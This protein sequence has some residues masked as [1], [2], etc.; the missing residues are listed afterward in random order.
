MV[1][2]KGLIGIGAFLAAVS[3]AY[4]ALK[5]DVQN[6]EKKIE[7]EI[8]VVQQQ[9]KT[10]TP[11]FLPKKKAQFLELKKK[12]AGAEAV[13]IL[14][15]QAVA[16]LEDLQNEDK[17]EG[18]IQSPGRIEVVVQASQRQLSIFLKLK[19]LPERAYNEL[20]QID[21][22]VFNQEARKRAFEKFSKSWGLEISGE[23]FY[24]TMVNWGVTASL[25]E[26]F[27]PKLFSGKVKTNDFARWAREATWI[28][29]AKE[30]KQLKEELVE[31][32]ALKAYNE[33]I[34]TEMALAHMNVDAS[35]IARIQRDI[36]AQINQSEEAER[37]LLDIIEV[38]VRERN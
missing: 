31:L 28:D 22:T 9:I 2:K 17:D 7:Q 36:E 30:A 15:G 26:S 25:E 1:K 12:D 18:G 32:H 19:N 10:S 35:R 4:L 24:D 27:F 5:K 14:L 38:I 33:S 29:A 21:K 37:Q 8:A 23:D 20:N 11:S 6:E 13:L 34:L 3:L 16:S